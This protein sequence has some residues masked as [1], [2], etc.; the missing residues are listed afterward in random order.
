[1]IFAGLEIMR[2]TLHSTSSTLH[3]KRDRIIDDDRDDVLD[4]DADRLPIQ[5][6][7]PIIIGLSLALW[8]GIG[9]AISALL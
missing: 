1:M 9:F 8:S 4:S 3:L 7:A 5:V 6:A 2:P